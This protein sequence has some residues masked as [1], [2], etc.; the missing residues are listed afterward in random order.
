MSLISA[1]SISLDSTFKLIAKN[2]R[3]VCSF[4]MIGLMIGS[5]SFGVLS[6]KFGRRHMLLVGQSHFLITPQWLLHEIFPWYRLLCMLHD[7]L[8]ITFH[9]LLLQ[10]SDVEV[11]VLQSR[12]KLKFI[13]KKN[14]KI[15]L[16]RFSFEC[17]SRWKVSLTKFSKSIFVKKK[18]PIRN[19]KDFTS[20]IGKETP[21][22]A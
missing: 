7:V 3:Y 1:G 16:T 10:K 9:S 14:I 17:I 2:A 13:T 8:Y 22:K 20:W 4:F 18:Y 5:F 15:G 21:C 12:S 11:N 6:D 19:K